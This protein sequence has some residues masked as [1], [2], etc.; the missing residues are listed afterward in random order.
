[1]QAC[2]KLAARVAGRGIFAMRINSR[3]ASFTESESG[4]D[5]ATSGAN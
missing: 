2:A 1:M 3:S 4:N 5:L